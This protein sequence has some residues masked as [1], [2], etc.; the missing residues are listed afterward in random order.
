[1][2]FVYADRVRETSTSTGTGTFALAGAVTGFR[3]FASGIG[4]NNTCYYTI[5][6]RTA[7]EWEVGY[8]TL[9]SLGTTLTRTAVQ[10][11]STGSAVVFSAGTKDVFVTIPAS[12]L[13]PISTPNSTGSALQALTLS[14][15]GT[16]AGNTAELRLLELA[17]NGTNYVGF[18]SADS[19]ASNLTWT[20]PNADGANGQVLT[21][22][23]SGT[24]S[25]AE[26]NYPAQGRLTLTSGVPVT[27]GDVTAATILYYTPYVGNQIAL[28]NGT[29][30]SVITFSE[31]SL[32]LSTIS[33]GFSGTTKPYDIFGYLS[34]G[35]LAI[36]GLVW[37]SE[38]VRATSLAQQ[39]GIYVKSGDATRRYLG[40]IFPSATNQTEDSES[41]RYVW[42]MYNRVVK[43]CRKADTTGSWTYNS[44]TVRIQNNTV[45]NRFD[46]I[47]GEPQ[48]IRVTGH[49]D[50]SVPSAATPR[51]WLSYGLVIPTSVTAGVGTGLANGARG[52]NA[53]MLSVIHNIGIDGSLLC[54]AG[55][56]CFMILENV[57]T[58]VAVTFYGGGT[59]QGIHGT[60]L[61]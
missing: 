41:K 54:T 53:N 30:W 39:N 16:S 43:N 36:E 51:L 7:S 18:K 47:C 10:S 60:W 21:T 48:G 3:T 35:S 58:T 4:A 49:C 32:T 25:W 24:L 34:S 13:S 50:V 1:M 5:S 40:T 44:S 37:T 9:D 59:S 8:G 55:F 29:T 22:N 57:N 14:P 2:P 20:L 42:N 23:G 46:V 17:A 27:T 52:L 61:C 33:G 15:F 6:H 45:A 12:A 56:T 31:V 19:V 11:S 38:K 26:A 28:Y